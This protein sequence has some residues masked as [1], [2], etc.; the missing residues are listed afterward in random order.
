MD[1]ALKLEITLNVRPIL[2]RDFHKLYVKTF[3]KFTWHVT[4]FVYV[5]PFTMDKAL[6]IIDD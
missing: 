1:T 6:T 4:L 5:L 3:L 2:I